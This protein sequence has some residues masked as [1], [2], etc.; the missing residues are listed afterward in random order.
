L[1]YVS[2]IDCPRCERPLVR[3]TGGRCTNCGELVTSHVA[4][5]RLREKRIEQVVAILATVLVLALFLWAG[6]FGLVE[7]ILVYVMGGVAVW[8]WGQRT[9]WSP[10][11][12]PPDEAPADTRDENGKPKDG[13]S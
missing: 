10:T 2:K 13:S 5:S 6:G 7:G 9:F 12:Q 11:L 3:K 8:L 4:R 1:P